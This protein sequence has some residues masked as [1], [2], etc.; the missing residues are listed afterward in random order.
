[1]PNY[2]CAAPKV[3]LS[4]AER[5]K[6]SQPGEIPII[7]DESENDPRFEMQGDTFDTSV[8]EKKAIRSTPYPEPG[9]GDLLSQ[10]AKAYVH[11]TNIPVAYVR[12][13]LKQIVLHAL[14]GM[15]F[16]PAYPKLS[17][18]GYHV[19]LGESDG[20]KTFGLEFA[21]E[22]GRPILTSNRIHPESL[23]RYKSEQT[24]IRSFTP[25]GTIKR[26]AKEEIKSGS[27]GHPS[28][29]LHIKEGNKVPSSSEYMRGVF[30]LLTDLY[31]QTETG[32]ESMTNGVFAVGG[33]KVSAAMCFTPSDHKSTFGGK[34]NIGGGGLTRLSMVNPPG[35]T[36]YDNKD[37]ERLPDSV[38]Q[39]LGTKLAERILKL[40]GGRATTLTEE[41]GATEIRLRTKAKLKLAGKVGKRLMDYFIRE[42]V[43]QAATAV[44]G[45][46]ILT[47]EQARYAERWV[48]AQLQVRLECWPSDSSNPIEGTGWIRPAS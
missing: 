48:M 32:T 2:L 44:D 8:Y 24:F 9:D 16:H 5:A 34:G 10:V 23:L 39:Q 45:R 17:L 22:A 11:G 25:E 35:I 26:G 36:D 3:V 46:L 30:S 43:A 31:D 41:P 38:L 4:E 18:R 1:M 14:D 13:P 37:W 6:Q 28:Q 12:E 29:F 33:I 42:Q 19:S 21:L 7:D 20:G 15:L 27:P 40:V 47:T